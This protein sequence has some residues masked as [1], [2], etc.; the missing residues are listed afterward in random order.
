MIDDH[1][2]KKTFFFP[3]TLPTQETGSVKVASWGLTQDEGPVR[4]WW[5]EETWSW[6][7]IAAVK[8]Q[9]GLEQVASHTVTPY[10]FNKYG[11]HSLRTW[12]GHWCQLHLLYISFVFST[13]NLPLACQDAP[14]RHVHLC[15]LFT[16]IMSPRR[17]SFFHTFNLCK[18]LAL[19][20]FPPL[21][22]WYFRKKWGKKGL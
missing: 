6:A 14:E 22:T 7:T 19:L 5:E 16:Q 15:L 8:S 10:Q 4:D 17:T 13:V 2:A 20:K 3:W 21:T 12:V 1:V 11:I 18:D 9:E